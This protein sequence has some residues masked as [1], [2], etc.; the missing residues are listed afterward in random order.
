MRFLVEVI[1]QGIMICSGA[2]IKFTFNFFSNQRL[3]LNLS[4]DQL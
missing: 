4:T 2:S 3:A 1:C